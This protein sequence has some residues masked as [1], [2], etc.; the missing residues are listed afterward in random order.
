MRRIYHKV[1]R[2]AKRSDGLANAMR[3]DDIAKGK[4]ASVFSKEVKITLAV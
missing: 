3:C 2:K 1:G 4:T